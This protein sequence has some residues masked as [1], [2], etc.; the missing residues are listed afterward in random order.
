MNIVNTNDQMVEV[1]PSLSTFEEN[2]KLQVRIYGMDGSLVTFTQDDP[3][4]VEHIVRDCQ[5]PD[6]FKQD[7]IAVAGQHSVTTLV[8]SNVARIDLAGEGLPPWKPPFGIGMSIRDIVELPEQ[9]FLYQVE[10]RDLKHVERRRVRFAP[11]KPA[12][13]YVAIQLVGGHHIYLKVR[14]VDVPRAERLQRL[15]SFMELPGLSFRLDGGGLG[16]VNLT[17]AVKFS[18]YPGPAEV[19]TATWSV[20]EGEGDDL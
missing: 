15:R 16:L 10:A 14:I 1:H 4:V 12:V 5:T 2:S 13:V 7:R 11:G 6:F 3:A 18:S 17:K 8:L 20:N 19:P 9:E